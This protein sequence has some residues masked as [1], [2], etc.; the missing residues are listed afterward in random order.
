[1]RLLA[2]INHGFLAQ[3][4]GGVDRIRMVEGIRKEGSL[5]KAVFFQ[6]DREENDGAYHMEGSI[7]RKQQS[8]AGRAG[9]L[10]VGQGKESI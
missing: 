8:G 10:S 7:C 9:Y 6:N 4:P 1:M 3:H 5:Q 2:V